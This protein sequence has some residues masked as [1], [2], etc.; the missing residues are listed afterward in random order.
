MKKTDFQML[1]IASM[2]G[3]NIYRRVYI[4]ENGR[5]YIKYNGEV[6]DVTE[7]KAYFIRG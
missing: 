2:N 5:Y 1:V 4:D 3:A 7:K 6:R